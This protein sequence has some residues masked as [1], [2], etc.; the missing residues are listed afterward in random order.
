MTTAADQN[1]AQGLSAAEAARRL[2]EVGP[3]AAPARRGRGLAR[4]IAETLREPMF[5]LLLAAAGLYLLLGDWREG[6]FLCLGATAALGLV[7]S[8]EARSERALAA[9]RDLS[10]PTARVLRDGEVQ[11]IPAREIVP[12]D[13][14]LIA[15]GERIPADGRLVSN[16]VLGVDES[17][18][19]GESALVDKRRAEPGDAPAGETAPDQL[20]A[21]TMTLRG[22]GLARV[23]RTGAAT[24]LGQIDASLAGLA[25]EPT[26]LQ[27]TAGRLVGWLGVMALAFCALVALAYGLVR[28]AWIDG[29]LA[30]LT[31]AIA[32]VPEE[33]PMVLA[34]FLALGAR[35]LARR[36]VLVRRNA[37]IEALGGATVLCVDKTGTLTENRMRVARLWPEASANELWAIGRLA[38]A[39]RPSDPMDRALQE[40]AKPS[41]RAALDPEP[42]RVWPLT[43]E[44]MAVIQAWRQADGVLLAAKGA[45]E[46][47]IAL[48]RLPAAEAEQ[49]MEEVRALAQA[50]LRVL[51]A[52]VREAQA[53]EAPDA[54]AFRFTGLIGFEDPLRADAP[55]AIA[56][57]RAAGVQVM[58]ITGDHP[59]TALAVARAAGLE[60]EAGVLLGAELAQLDASALAA[61]LATVRVFARVAPEQKLALVQALKA[62]GEVVVMT[63]DGVND[64]P[65]LE[66]AHIGVAMGRRGSDVAREAADLV[67]LDDSFASIV[68]GVRLGRRIFANLR[69]ALTYVTAIHVPVAGLAIAPVLLG[70][71]PLLYPMHVMLLELAIDPICALVF[72]GEPSGRNA[73][74]HPP[75][76]REEA[77]F[78]AA[79]L[80]RAMVQGLGVLAAVLAVYLIGLQQ[81]SELQAR[82]AAF[83]AL[84]LSNLVLALADAASGGGRLFGRHRWIFW[85]ISAALAVILSLVM[86]VPALA[87]L[88]RI[89][90]PPAALLG[91]ALAAAVVGGGWPLVVRRAG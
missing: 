58:M 4:I 89:A 48:C 51:G 39:P 90:P 13:L 24:S 10:Q 77:L 70:L 18:L 3:N 49:V 74:R 66:A 79:E 14:V 27:R 62:R 5:L 87:Q 7:I 67:L 17:I 19:T 43:A 15:E 75:R 41:G 88:F 45:P 36:R 28:G 69:R 34:V 60:V 86:Y 33:F 56:E 26:P 61:R 23:T 84:A 12:G 52:C 47:I 32:L 9:L 63:G 40:G 72:E 59:S 80:R 22:Q 54:A 38:S 31:V 2:S 50:G 55:A 35:R 1:D 29:G 57:A 20:F 85:A 76:K 8:Q 42:S 71:P 44:R 25:E 82:G 46:A 73:M 91:M 64:A 81:A 65:A 68:G 30:G 11:R 53:D 6:I 78:G 83:L 37:A 16:D 21:G